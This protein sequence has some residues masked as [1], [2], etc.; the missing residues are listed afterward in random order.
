ML[1]VSRGFCVCGVK[2][3]THFMEML[4]AVSCMIGVAAAAGGGVE[5][6]ANH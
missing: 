1:G 6:G 3:H 2:P 5:K 4:P